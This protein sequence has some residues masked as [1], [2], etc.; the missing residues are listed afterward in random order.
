MWCESLHSQW[1]E[2]LWVQEITRRYTEV[3]QKYLKELEEESIFILREAASTREDLVMLYSIGKDSSVMLHLAEKAFAP[4]PLPF[5][6][7]HIDTGYKFPEM[8]EMRDQIAK[9][10]K[11]IVEHN[12]DWFTVANPVDLGCDVCCQHLKTEA[13]LGALKKHGFK[14]AFGGARRD[15]EKSRAKER[16]FSIRTNNKWNPKNQRPELWNLYNT[17]TQENESLR[18]FPLSNWTE[19]DVWEYIKEE[20]IPVL[21]LYFSKERSLGPNNTMVADGKMVKCRFRSLGC[22]PCTGAAE[23]DVYDVDGIIDELKGIRKSERQYR[24][25]DQTSDSSMEKKKENGYF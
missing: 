16:V 20:S 25:I 10:H 13:L 17:Q 19:L 23:S 4:A 18:I 9:K 5:P 14:A 3:M 2:V 6:L 12:P 7:M 8:Y 15:E 24:V 22:I 11:L 1:R 21:D